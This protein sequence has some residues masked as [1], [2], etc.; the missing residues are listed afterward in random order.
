MKRGHFLFTPDFGSNQD[1]AK[2][3]LSVYW[4]QTKKNSESLAK[5]K[6]EQMNCSQLKELFEKLKEK[7]ND[8]LT[9]KTIETE[10]KS[11]THLQTLVIVRM[12]N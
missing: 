7:L 1:E 8:T 5:V 2:K 12:I 10:K 4:K 3:S 9:E 6:I 11:H